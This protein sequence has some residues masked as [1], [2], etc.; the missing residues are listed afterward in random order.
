MFNA[1]KPV[2]FR[3]DIDGFP[4]DLQVLEFRAKERLNQPY[5]VN[6]E[7][8]SERPDL[9]LESML[10]RSAFLRF[11]PDSSGIHGQ[12]YQVAQG[13]SGKRLTRYQ[14]TLVPHVAYLAHSHNQRIFQKL[15][16]QAMPEAMRQWS[17][18]LTKE[19]WAKPSEKLLR[20]SA[21]VRALHKRQPH[22]PITEIF[23]EVQRLNPTDKRR[24]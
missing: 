17:E 4:R 8:V 19:Q 7:L 1:S 24:A 11:G 15:A 22:R 3:L 6:L 5:K 20:L 12:V 21:Q 10:H 18:P 14:M 13:D 2:V 23:A 16:P 9:D